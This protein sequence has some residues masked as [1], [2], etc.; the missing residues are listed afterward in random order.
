MNASH[1]LAEVT[2]QNFDPPWFWIF[3][4]IGSLGVLALTYRDIYR[5]SGRRLTWTLFIVRAL[6]LMVLIAALI[7]P[8]WRHVSQETERPQIAVIV[9][10]SQSMSLPPSGDGARQATRYQQARWWLNESPA[11]K[12]LRDRFDVRLFDVAGRER[13]AGDL[14]AEPNAEQTD[15][16]RA[17]RSVAGRLRGR[18]AAGV[19]LISDGQDTTGR[20]SYLPLQEYPLPAYALGFR[21]VR[22]R[23]GAAVD[24]AVGSVDAPARTLVHNA[25]EIKV[26]V[27][28]DG[29]AALE[30]PIYVERAGT[31]VVTER[32][33]LGQ[34]AVEKLVSL[35]F[36]P[37]EPG[38]FVMTARLGTVKDERTAVNN[39]A[40]FRM[41]VEADPI[42]VLYIEGTLRA[43]HKF[44]RQRLADDPDVDLITF[45][46]AASPDEASVSGVLAGSELVSP[47]RLKKID[48]VLLGD[49][50][51][52]MLDPRAYEALR[53][54]VEAGGGLM[55]LGGYRNLSED[56]L[57][58]TP[59]ADLLPVEP[60]A[61]GI[62]QIDQPFRFA[63]T[64]EGRRHPAL[65]VTGDM[66]RD[67]QLWE[68]LPQ[69]SGIVAV[70]RAKPGA[71]VLARHPLTDPQDPGRQGYVVLA[72]Q[73]FGK[74]TVTVFTADTTWRWSRLTRLAG[75][76]DTLYVRFWSQMVRW[77][78]HRDATSDRTALTVST[79]SA[80][81]ERG[82]RVAVSVRRNAAV[83]L[84]GEDSAKTS[85]ALAVS[86]PDGRTMPLA[87]TADL[88]DS[89]RWTA[90]FFPDRGGRFVVAARLVRDGDGG[91]ADVATQQSEFLVEGSQIELEDPT[92]NAAVMGQIARLTGGVYAEIDDERAT[93]DL[94]AALPAAPRVVRHV[95]TTHLWNSPALFSVFLVLVCA[96]WIVR[97]RN[98]LV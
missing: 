35:S 55:V 53:D 69:L 85:L 45:A 98:H 70:K 38:D 68:S 21:W 10:D 94:V 81:Y 78:A 2:L 52:R 34:G 89:N 74:G 9:D 77:L 32:V 50:E 71:T 27:R 3:L 22:G 25:A 65:S 83:V 93:A 82:Q 16:V 17:M 60:L 91:S 76:P 90:T 49:F 44:L 7:K 66:T 41:R 61:G 36:T 8:A 24:L 1:C 19:L 80:S 56:G 47:D 86:T 33:A 43:E 51:S 14:P 92:P 97:R 57:A 28:K 54:W 46:R 62:E 5:R 79:A 48:V 15:L 37:A 26:L 20:R 12:A 73:P 87:P 29:G 84:P 4:A 72:T 42:R 96:E 67:A 30:V 31:P 23:E 88:A 18:N 13:E 95:R 64:P 39:T 11:G 75:K 58:R 40:L 6:G 59:L 63:L